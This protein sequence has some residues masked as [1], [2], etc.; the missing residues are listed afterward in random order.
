MYA[1]IFSA[2]INRL[3]D[4]YEQRVQR[5]NELAFSQ[6]NCIDTLSTTENGREITISYWHSLDD[7]QKWKQDAEHIQAQTLGRLHWYSEYEVQIVEVLRE[8]KHTN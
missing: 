2:T 1:V 8:Y 4:D 3:D 5:L 7:I 6:Y